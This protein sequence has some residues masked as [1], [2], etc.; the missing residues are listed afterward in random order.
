VSQD[1]E[2][3]NKAVFEKLW[4]TGT[5]TYESHPTTRHRRRFVMKALKYALATTKD[6]PFLFDY[7]C[8]TGALLREAQALYGL[9]DAQLGGCDLSDKAIEVSTAHIDSPHFYIGKYPELNK[10]I[11][12]AICTEVIEH[13]PEYERI[14]SWVY[15]H[16]RPG[17]S[18]ILTTPG[19]PMDPPDESYGHTQHFVLSELCD[20]MRRIGFE[21]PE[22]RRWGFPLF[23]LQ[24]A[25]T[26]RM[27]S[28][29]EKHVIDSPM[30]PAKRLVFRTAYYAYLVHDV[31]PRGPQ[32]FIR[33]IKPA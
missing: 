19:V 2:A 3:H 17:G 13:T 1:Y 5:E 31:I 20:V 11:D 26:K 28:Q 27:F 6:Q 22:A 29:I 8:G 30:G 18:F 21:L 9:A 16:L 7:G 24:K 4:D 33:A 15:E 10:A 14:L 25:I 12:V 32:I 23:S